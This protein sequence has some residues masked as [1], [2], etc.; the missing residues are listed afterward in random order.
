M[1][2]LTVCFNGNPIKI[3]QFDGGIIT[4]GRDPDNTLRIE[5]L[6]HRAQTPHHRPRAPRRSTPHAGGRT[7]S[8]GGQRAS[9]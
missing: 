8:G 9:H 5:A 7:L 1:V 4:I 2:K 6:R 3:H